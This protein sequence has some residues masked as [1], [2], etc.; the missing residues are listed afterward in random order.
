MRSCNQK[1]HYRITERLDTETFVE[2][3][4]LNVQVC[5]SAPLTEFSICKMAKVTRVTPYSTVFN[6]KTFYVLRCDLTIRNNYNK[7]F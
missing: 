2:S 6:I 4:E 5:L 1:L 3:D 7:L